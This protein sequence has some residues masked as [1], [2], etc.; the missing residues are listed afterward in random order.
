MLEKMQD[1]A[2]E[3]LS[4]SDV[5]ASEAPSPPQGDSNQA[6]ASEAPSNDNVKNNVAQNKQT[7]DESDVSGNNKK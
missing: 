6:L 3:S 2:S 5:P 4:N 7:E 1:D